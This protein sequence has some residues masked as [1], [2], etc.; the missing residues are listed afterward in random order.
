MTWP[1]EYLFYIF[2]SIY[3]FSNDISV[4]VI[5]KMYHIHKC[6]ILNIPRIYTQKLCKQSVTFVIASRK[7]INTANFG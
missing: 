7:T 3:L 1:S 2:S 6:K 5:Y 4:G